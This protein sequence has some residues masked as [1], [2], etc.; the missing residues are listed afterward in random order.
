MCVVESNDDTRLGCHADLCGG[1]CISDEAPLSRSVDYIGACLVMTD[2][3]TRY[4]NGTA[5]LCPGL[6]CTGDTDE[7]VAKVRAVDSDLGVTCIKHGELHMKGVTKI[8][9]CCSSGSTSCH[10]ACC[11]RTTVDLIVG[12][13]SFCVF[14]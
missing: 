4:H 1:N 3:H 10:V 5:C 7:W 12:A 2:N 11:W 13:C 9:A 8:G 14:T 6:I